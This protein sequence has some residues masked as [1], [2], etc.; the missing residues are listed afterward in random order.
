MLQSKIGS[1]VTVDAS[2]RVAV[3]AFTGAGLR[4]VVE[5]ANAVGLRVKPVG[6]GLARNQVPTAG[7][8]VPSGTEIVVRFTR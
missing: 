6:S 7:T 4:S 2:K 1:G 5:Q 8:M 3:P